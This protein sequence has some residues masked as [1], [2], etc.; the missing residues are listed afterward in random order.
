[1]FFIYFMGTR[2]I[3]NFFFKNEKF[4]EKLIKMKQIMEKLKK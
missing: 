3:Y 1:M 4:L 2:D